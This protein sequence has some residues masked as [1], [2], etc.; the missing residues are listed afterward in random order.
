MIEENGCGFAS[1]MGVCGVVE[2]EM[3]GVLKG[4]ELAWSEGCRRVLVETD[5]EVVARH[6]KGKEVV[7]HM[8]SVHRSVMNLLE[9]EWQLGVCKIDR[10]NNSCTDALAKLGLRLE[11]ESRFCWDVPFEVTIQFGRDKYTAAVMGVGAHGPD[12]V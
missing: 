12:M 6:L 3:W 7:A 10:C 9:R 2:A 8:S 11:E 5:S 1:R 4:L